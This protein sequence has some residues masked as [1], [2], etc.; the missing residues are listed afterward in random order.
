MAV[1]AVVVRALHRMVH[2]TGG[3]RHIGGEKFEHF[4][5]GGVKMPAMHVPRDS[6]ESAPEMRGS[7]RAHQGNRAAILKSAE[8]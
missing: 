1:A 6:L 7:L 5:Q 4:E 8:Q 3:Q 2:V